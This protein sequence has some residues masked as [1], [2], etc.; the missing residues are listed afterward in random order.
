MFLGLTGSIAC[1]KSTTARILE[2]N[3]FTVQKRD[4]RERS[5]EENETVKRRG[6]RRS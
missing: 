3:G 5:S 6:K 1:G 2:Q 4:E